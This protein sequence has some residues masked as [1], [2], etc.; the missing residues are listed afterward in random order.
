[1]RKVTYAA[2]ILKTLLQ[3]EKTAT[4][5]RL[6]TVLGTTVKMTVMRK[7]KELS[8]IGSYSHSGKY[9]TLSHIPEFDKNGIWTYKGV[10][11]SIYGNLQQTV[12]RYI[13]NTKNGY[14][15]SE[16]KKILDIEVKEGLLALYRKKRIDRK[17]IS[18]CYVYFSTSPQLGKSQVLHRKEQESTLGIPEA[19]STNESLPKKITH[20]IFLF[21]S[22]LNEK[23]QRLYAG[24]ESIKMG[25]G[26][27][28]KV[29][30]LL[31]MDPHTVAKGRSDII[32]EKVDMQRVRKKGG[33]RI[34]T[35]K[36]ARKP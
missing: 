14:S 9:Y 19:Q 29:A 26:G 28:K 17:K 32:A 2:N 27:D 35:E 23:Q 30:S 5:D 8:Y 6:K 12:Q 16:L 18:G 22:T 11:F 4:M 34:L 36:K 31:G 3:E 24:L 33:G 13:E 20:L 25:Y 10:K 1:M 21:F 15:A 7:M